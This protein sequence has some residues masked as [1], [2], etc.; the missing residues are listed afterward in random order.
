M[1]RPVNAHAYGVAP[2]RLSHSSRSSARPA[3]S[4]PAPLTSLVDREQELE[5]GKT[6]LRDGDVRLVT[7]TGPPGTGKSRL[8]VVIGAAVAEGFP[9]G[10][11]FVPLAPLARPDMVLPT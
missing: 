5:L 6:L 8:A 4:L 3:T 10:V 11:W 1:S 2:A 7:L 9:D